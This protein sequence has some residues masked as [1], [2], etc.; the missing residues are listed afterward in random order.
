MTWL[1]GMLF[2][3]RFYQLSKRMPPKVLGLLQPLS[4]ACSVIWV[5]IAISIETPFHRWSVPKQPVR[6]LLVIGDSV[7]AGLNDGES[8]WPRQLSESVDVRV[9]DAS[10][11]GATLKSALQQNSR[12]A[13][14]PGLII[15]EIGGNDMLE[16]LPVAE[17]EKN[18]GNLLAEV[19]H[20]DRT[21]VMFELPLPPFHAMYVTA[22]RRQAMRYNVPLIPKRLF[23]RILTTQG[24]TVDGIHLSHKGQLQMKALIE[25]LLND[26]LK[27]GSGTYEQLPLVAQKN[28]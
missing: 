25:S 20:P 21:V 18:L 27:P 28:I 14:Q 16:G 3:T 24:S 22:Q 17:F 10:Q 2:H 1:I 8:T 26:R 7:T 9:L 13:G 12:F 19:T 5:T 23:A 4:V 15:L 6:D 11:P